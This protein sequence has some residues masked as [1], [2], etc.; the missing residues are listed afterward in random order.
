M[1]FKESNLKSSNGVKLLI[2]TQ[3][4]DVNDDVLGFFH[5]WVEKLAEKAEEIYVIA[6]FVGKLNLPQNVKI[7]SLGKEKGYSRCWRYFLFY[8]N[9]FSILPKIDGVFFHM[10]PEYVIAAG[11]LPKIFNKKTLLWYTHKSVNLKLRFA[12]KLV[13]RI[14]TASKE[15]FRLPSKK[16]EITGHGIDIN[17]FKRQNEKGKITIQN[18]KFTII[19]AGRISPIKNLDVLIEVAEILKGKNFEFEIKIAGK[20][21]LKSDEAYFQKLENSIK[22]KGLGDK[23]IFL[24]SIPYAEIEKFY[25]SANL[26]INLSDTGSMDKAALEAMSCGVSVFTSNEAFKEILPEK[27]FTEKK[28]EIIAE[29]IIKMENETRDIS[30]RLRDY[31]IKNHNLDNLVEKI[32]KFYE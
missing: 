25:Q 16:I 1:I 19:T 7:L 15:S 13:D 28:P 8:K 20:P 18:Q 9:L 3:K 32:A 11:L 6:N 14:F 21:A 5:G 17:K 29:K 30:L 4:V 22:E 31:V 27:Y 2:I 26:F 12:E 23:I 10:C 24:G